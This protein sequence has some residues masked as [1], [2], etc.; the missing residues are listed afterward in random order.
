MRIAT[1]D[2]KLERTPTKENVETFVCDALASEPRLL[3]IW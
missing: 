1:E 3:I 2:C